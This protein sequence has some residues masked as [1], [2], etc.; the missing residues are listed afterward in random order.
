MRTVSE[1][2]EIRNVLYAG[3]SQGVKRLA[4]VSS[5]RYSGLSG[6]SGDEVSCAM[7]GLVSDVK[8]VI[9]G[10]KTEDGVGFPDILSK[11]YYEPSE[12]GIT[13]VQFRVNSKLKSTMKFSEVKSISVGAGMVEE[14][15]EF[16]ISCMLSLFDRMQAEE[17]LAALNDRVAGI[18]E[19]QGIPFA[20]SFACE[21]V[22]SPVLHIDD[23][24]IQFN[25][26][27]GKA[28]EVSRMPIFAAGDGLDDYVA[29]RAE[30]ALV[31]ALSTVQTP[32]QLIK[33]KKVELIRSMVDLST[34]A[35]ANKIIRKAYHRQAKY[36]NGVK[37][38]FG[39]FDEDVEINGE[40]VNVFAIVEKAEDGSLSV[41]LSPFDVKTNLIVD[42]DVLAAVGDQ[43]KEMAAVT[44]SA[45]QADAVADAAADSSVDA[46]EDAAADASV[47]AE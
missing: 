18:C 23:K 3:A 45:G 37:A 1:I 30:E 40:K 6:K 10:V 15:G 29:A 26:T 24:G 13:S 31:A 43:L 19:G 17:N 22:N 41:V 27:V 44:G 33:A 7:A 4:E 47:A 35:R 28:F 5:D 2:N 21:P 36:L 16:Y 38:G 34:K 8:A 39:Y 46:T 25:V 32:V 42:F 12:N 11:F 20:V 14:L 9:L